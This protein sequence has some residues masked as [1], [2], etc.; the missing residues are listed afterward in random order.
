MQFF[1]GGERQSWERERVGYRLTSHVDIFMFNVLAASSS[2]LCVLLGTF[3]GWAVC[4]C[5]MMLR[6]DI[7]VRMK[8]GNLARAQTSLLILSSQFYHKHRNLVN[9]NNYCVSRL[10]IKT[11]PA[12]NFTVITNYQDLKICSISWGYFE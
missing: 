10:Q 5:W 12:E 6:V 4:Y 1:G 2:G 8:I 7:N 9:L 3:I 11:I